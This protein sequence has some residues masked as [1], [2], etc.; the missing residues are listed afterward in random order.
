VLSM[1]ALSRPS[2]HLLAAEW[3]AALAPRV[4]RDE[5]KF[6]DFGTIFDPRVETAGGGTTTDQRVVE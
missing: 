1:S 6:E 2:A 4:A 5:D 3:T